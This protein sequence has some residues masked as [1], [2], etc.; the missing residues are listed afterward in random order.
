MD[1]VLLLLQTIQ[2]TLHLLQRRVQRVLYGGG[3]IRRLLAVRQVLVDMGNGGGQRLG[4]GGGDTAGAAGGA[5]G[6][7]H[8]AAPG[9]YILGLVQKALH[10]GLRIGLRQIGGQQIALLHD[11]A[12]DHL[13][14]V[15]ADGALQRLHR[16]VGDLGGHGVFLGVFIVGDGGLAGP[17][18]EH[19][20]HLAGEVLVDDHGGIVVAGV[21][22][23]HR[24]LL[25]VHDDPVDGR[26]GFQIL[27]HVPALID[28]LTVAGVAPVQ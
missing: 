11:A 26:G 25:R 8:I 3:G 5:E 13:Q 4:I 1:V 16:R 7:H 17:V 20:V 19:P 24:L 10:R 23:V 28:V 27:L 18:R 6:V 9:Q 12:D 14:I 2:C 21:H 15:L 22:A